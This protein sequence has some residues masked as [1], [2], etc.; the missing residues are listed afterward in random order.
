MLI[1][2][3]A[4]LL[5]TMRFATFSG[6]WNYLN[7]RT[8]WMPS[9]FRVALKIFTMKTANFPALW[10]RPPLLLKV[11]LISRFKLWLV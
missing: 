7:V 8:V 1:H 5:Q 6:P 9:Y 3:A 4:P 10:V 11:A 2:T